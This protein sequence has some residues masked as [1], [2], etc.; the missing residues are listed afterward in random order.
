MKRISVNIKGLVELDF[1]S[2]KKIID[3]LNN[4]YFRIFMAQRGL[5][6]IYRNKSLNYEQKQTLVRRLQE[7][8]ANHRNE[9]VNTYS[10]IES[11]MPIGEKIISNISD[12]I[13]T[14]FLNS[15]TIFYYCLGK[16]V[17]ENPDMIGVAKRVLISLAEKVLE[18]DTSTIKYK[19]SILLDNLYLKRKES[20]EYVYNEAIKY[21][22]LIEKYDDICYGFECIKSIETKTKPEITMGLINPE[23]E[24]GLKCGSE[25][26]QNIV[27]KRYKEEP[28]AIESFYRCVICKYCTLSN[29]PEE[30]KE[31]V[32]EDLHRQFSNRNQ[33]DLFYFF[34]GEFQSYI[35]SI[36]TYIYVRLLILMYCTNNS[37]D[38]I[39]VTDIKKS[40]LG[41]EIINDD[42]FKAC[43]DLVASN[44]II[45]ECFKI[46][47]HGIVVGRWQ[48]D[49]DLN[50][51]EL[52]KNISLNSKDEKLAGLSSNQFGKDVYEKL[53]R[54]ML[55]DN[56]WFVVPN[57]IK[58]KL[59]KAGR[60]D[61]DL[62]AYKSGNVIVGQVKLANTGRT[63]FELWKAYESINKGVNQTNFSLAKFEEDPNLLYS[64]LKQ[65]GFC[66]KKDDIVK[67][68]PIVITSSS[69]FIGDMKRSKIP[70]VSWDMFC[71]IIYSVNYFDK[72]SEI[73]SYFYN[74]CS[75]YGFGYSKNII[76]SEVDQ[77][78]YNIKFEEFEEWS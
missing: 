3:N 28:G 68:I 55:E 61:I 30:R 13:K 7:I 76:I 46:C 17:E 51:I 60:T 69:Y 22:V 34:T 78:E 35:L 18:D 27:R 41:N 67:I 38:F 42:D 56:E 14:E 29:V 36:V 40:F 52:A 50:I 12:I 11:F 77:A 39:E 73:D 54:K 43:Y 4:D 64:I 59:Q 19:L 8:M 25:F 15:I 16:Y 49:R 65:Y 21:G 75:V 70:I 5:E 47:D 32:F 63:K 26:H 71:Q 48:Y 10:F 62:V 31:L 37:M 9:I 44:K 6:K 23:F 33:T 1:L 2:C 45:A 20:I 57:A 66:S 72:L 53:I 58:I 74:L 24:F